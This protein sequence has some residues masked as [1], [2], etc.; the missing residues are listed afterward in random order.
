M[1]FPMKFIETADG[2][3]RSFVE[4]D[5]GLTVHNDIPAIVHSTTHPFEH[6]L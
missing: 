1:L 2:A 3:Y 4:G 5:V 6:A